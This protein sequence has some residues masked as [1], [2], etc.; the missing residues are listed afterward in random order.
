MASDRLAEQLVGARI[1]RRDTLAE[2][3]L[4][5]HGGHGVHAYTDTGREVAFWNVGDWEHNNASEK[6]VLDSMAER[7]EFQ[8]YRDFS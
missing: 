5:W 7:Q 8:D 6:D 3:T 2:L 4:A 1:V